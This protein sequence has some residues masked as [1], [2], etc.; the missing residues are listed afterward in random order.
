MSENIEYGG[1]IVWQPTP[2]YIQNARVTEF[3]NH[4]GLTSYEQ[5]IP[6]SNEDV[7]W[8]TEALIKFLDI[9]FYEPY[10]KVIDLSNGIMWPKWCVD[11][12]LNIVHNCLDKY[13]GTPT[14]GKDAF[15]WEGEE[16]HT[17]KITYGELYRLTNQTANALRSLGLGKGDAIG[18]FMPMTIE[19]IAAFL[20]IAKI[21][22][23]IVPLFSGYGVSAVVT[24]L[25]DTSAKALFTCDGFFRRGKVVKVKE[26]ADQ[27][28]ER[29]PSLEHMIVTQRAQIDTPMQPARDHWWHDLIPIQSQEAKTEITNAEDIIMIIY[30]S[31]TTGKPKGAVHTH[32]GFP[33]K[34]TQD[35][36]FGMDMHK[37][38]I[39]YWITD[40]GWML[41]P[42]MVFGPT[43]VGGT[44]FLYDG[45]LDYP[46]PDR[47]W[48]M[49]ERHRIN[50]L[51]LSPT[52]IRALMP[53]G[54][55]PVHSHD[56]SSL[57]S[58]G[59]TGEPWNPAPWNWLFETVLNKEKPI[60]N[61]TG[62][63]E[64]A[65]GILMGNPTLPI[66]PTSFPCPNPGI[67]ADVMDEDGQ[68]VINQVGE[69]VVRFPWIGLTRGFWKDPQRYENTYWSRWPGVYVHGDWAVVDNDKQ[70]YVLGRS[71]DTIKIAGKRL[72][73]AEV[74]NI[75]VEHENVVEAAA[76]GV[77]HE[78]KGSEVVVFCVLHPDTKKNE[79]L[80]QEIK[81]MVSRQ[82]G[83]PLAPR[84]VFFISD[85]P[86]TRNAKVMRRMVRSAY[87]DLDHGDTSSLV[88]PE[89]LIEIKKIHK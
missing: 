83:K 74:E 16:G 76:I 63:T 11:G 81:E 61:Y 85:L 14:E 53:F 6:R 86:K 17:T 10:T 38:E 75:V 9:Q 48:D 21:G 55:E 73:P 2:Q 1:K 8:F 51:G 70:W 31:G 79:K 54:D 65:G 25:Q 84:D 59:S 47:L 71:D 42:W 66:K 62:G 89:I 30:T 18:I 36:V 39:I 5:L 34:S 56:L 72:G 87:L 12:K 23:I 20:A 28:A 35:V 50:L 37:D 3:M 46:G 41:G 60:I 29:V 24:R 43:I 88:N 22:A 27:A 68:P 13:I 52:L 49:V 69:L 19:I 64:C 7:A 82:M 80:K 44:G 45:A 57:R 4:N 33:I 77:P 78:I 67:A 15:I 40:M 26:I 58:I 32:C